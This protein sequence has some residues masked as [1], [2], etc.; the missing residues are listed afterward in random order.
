M[1]KEFAKKF[2][3]SKRW[4]RCRNSYIANRIMIDGG[5]CEECHKE[6]GYILHH[7]ITLTQSNIDNPDISLNHDN[8]MY[9]CKDCHDKYEGHGV[10]NSKVGLLVM[11]DEQGQPISIRDIDKEESGC[12]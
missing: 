5:L 1:A 9:V 11:F 6:L 3:N 10:C 12:I 4:K 7:K 2:Y 8:L